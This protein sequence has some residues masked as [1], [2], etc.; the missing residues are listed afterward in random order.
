MV[1]R[2]LS[3]PIALAISVILAHRGAA[4][5]NDYASGR[6][7]RFDR[8]ASVQA[9]SEAKRKAKMKVIPDQNCYPVRMR[10]QSR[11]GETSGVSAVGAVV[12]RERSLSGFPLK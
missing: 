6:R 8:S 10:R 2:I 11:C 3:E 9:R 7:I 4:E 5:C 12:G 1:G